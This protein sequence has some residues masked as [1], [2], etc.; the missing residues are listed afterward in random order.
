MQLALA[1]NFSDLRQLD[2]A[3]SSRDAIPTR[4]GYGKKKFV[5]VAAVESPVKRGL[6]RD[7]GT[8]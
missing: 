7:G 8:G 1:G 3:K 2:S 6:L 4:R 5:V